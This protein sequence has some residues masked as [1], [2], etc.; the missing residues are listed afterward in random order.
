MKIKRMWSL[1]QGASSSVEELEEC[2]A[3]YNTSQ[4]VRSNHGGMYKV[5][6]TH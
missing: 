4:A 5:L 3:D 6:W 1:F 2:T